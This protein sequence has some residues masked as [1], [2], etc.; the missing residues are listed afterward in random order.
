VLRRVLTFCFFLGC[1]LALWLTAPTRNEVFVSSDDTRSTLACQENLRRISLAFAQYAEDFD[2][3]F[4][5]G[6]DPEDRIP[7]TWQ[8]GAGGK[9][10]VDAQ[11]APL[12]VDLLL[13]YLHTRKV[14]RCPDDNGWAERPLGFESRLGVVQPSSWVKFGTSYYYY[15]MHGFAGLRPDDFPHPE[16]DLL[17]FDGNF[18]HVSEPSHTLNALFGDGH[19]ENLPPEK[20]GALGDEQARILFR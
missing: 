17:L 15:T 9:Y 11:S 19:V 3:K 14:W 2:G 5:R 8:S 16:R 1:A 6:V 20:F 10:S 7:Q 12:L 13:P 4:P 18:W